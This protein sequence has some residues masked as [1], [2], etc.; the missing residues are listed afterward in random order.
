[1]TPTHVSLNSIPFNRLFNGEIHPG[2]FTSLNLFATIS[3]ID[4]NTH[5]HTHTHSTAVDSVLF[6]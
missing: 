6:Y 2:L 3:C 5:T 1:M 4:V